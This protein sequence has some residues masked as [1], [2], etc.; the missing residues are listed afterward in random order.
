MTLS[1]GEIA[2]LLTAIALLLVAAHGMGQVFVHFRQPR[3]IGEIGGGLL[4]GPT[5]LSALLPG[6]MTW[7][8]PR[9]GPI[10][11]VLAA[12]YQLGLILL[13]YTAGAEMRS[14]FQVGERRLVIALSA[15]GTAVPFAAGLLLLT[16]YDASDHLGTAG[17]ET[18][19]L[20]VFATAIAVTSI[21]VI[22]RIMLDLGILDT[23]FARIVLATAVVEDI[24]LYVVLAV[25]LGLVQARQHQI[26]GLADLLGLVPGSGWNVGYHVIA[27]TL[28]LG[29]A[30]LLGPWLFRRTYQFRFNIL[31]WSNPIGFQIVFV[32]A[33]TGLC[34]FLGVTSLLGALVAGL[35]ASTS[36]EP[37]AVEAREGIKRFAAAFFVPAYFALVGFRLDLRRDLDAWF[38]VWFLC[39][40]CLTKGLSLYASARAVGE[41]HAVALNLAVALNAR[42]GP[43]IVL[44]SAALDAGIIDER[45]F[46]VLVLLAVATSLMAG[47]WL[48]RVV[49]AGSPLR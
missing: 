39:F 29:L 3:V 34:L 2:R 15:G 30:L 10:P 42:G 26:F 20:L 8:F 21:P 11:A 40:A 17:S 18:A 24:V 13:M 27:T 28:F 32:L 43:G 4:L 33:V 23:P 22:S 9:E 37:R 19:F 35:V 14:S 5:F 47:T 1:P 44:A 25:A 49:R 48:G 38:L 45:F 46:A 7:A 31:R 16:V 41:P 36:T 6:P 12:I